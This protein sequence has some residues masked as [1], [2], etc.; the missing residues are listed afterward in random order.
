MPKRTY[1]QILD[2]HLHI[3]IAQGSYDAFINL[4]KRYHK[5]AVQLATDLYQQYRY[6][7]ISFNEL[8]AACEDYFPFTICK[9]VPGLSTFY[10]FWKSTTK[11]HLINYIIDFSYDGNG[12]PINDYISF[13]QKKDESHS[14]GELIG[15]TNDQSVVKRKIFEI[16]HILHKYNLF[17]TTQEKALINCVLEGYS[18][19]DF[20]RSGALG[21]SQISLTYKSAVNK[22][23]KYMELDK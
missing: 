7:G 14:F 8:L 17:F 21:R 12:V 15:E 5:H 23:K 6:T 1:H 22:L 10:C 9:F 3:L 20:K 11:L 18:L 13:D 2:E 19:M 16:K 4:R